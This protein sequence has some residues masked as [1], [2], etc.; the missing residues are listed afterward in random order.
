[1][2]R[3]YDPTVVATRGL[4]Q[5]FD[6]VAE[7]SAENVWIVEVGRRADAGDFSSFVDRIAAAEVE[8]T[9]PGGSAGNR[10][11]ARYVSPTQ[12]E[13]VFSGR[14]GLTVGGTEV[15]LTD[16]PRLE[17]PWGEVCHLGKYLALTEG[18]SSLVIDFDKGARE[19]S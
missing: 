9:R 11:R 7:G 19:V 17:S 1:V 12:G 15:P 4:V 3:S 6:L 13:L 18:G 16:H 10:Q 5:P 14:G 2:W 8:V